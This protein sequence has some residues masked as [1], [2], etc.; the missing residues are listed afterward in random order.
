MRLSGRYGE[1]RPAHDPDWAAG[2]DALGRGGGTWND[3]D[4][5]TEPRPAR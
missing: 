3:P 5:P 2:L 1:T 4:R